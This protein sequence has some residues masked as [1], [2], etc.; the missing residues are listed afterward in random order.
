[1]KH[2]GTAALDQLETLL[3]QLRALEVLR[4]KSRGVF[5]VRSKPFL[6]FH[7][8]PT[9][10]FAD[11]RSGAD[12]ERYPVNSAAERKALVVAVKERL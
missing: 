9:G 5:Y 1:M 3:Q 12:F 2:A 4:E 7:D 8:D 6:H 10:L 11:L